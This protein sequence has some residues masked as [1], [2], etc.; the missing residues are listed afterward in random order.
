MTTTAHPDIAPP[1]GADASYT[2]DWQSPTDG[3]P[4][5]R[6][7]WSPEFSRGKEDIRCVVTQFEDGTVATEGDDGPH[8]YL[9]DS[10]H[11]V[12]D[13]RRIAKAILAAAD[14]AEQWAGNGCS[15]CEH[16]D[17]CPRHPKPQGRV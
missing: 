8:V 2:D 13:A 11:T 17:S 5:Y 16:W 12:A 4:G 15:T 1:P 6:C 14:L 3:A 7:V 9:N 10:G